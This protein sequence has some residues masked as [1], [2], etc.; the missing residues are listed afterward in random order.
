MPIEYPTT[1][2][3]SLWEDTLA[4]ACELTGRV[5]PPSTEEANS[6]KAHMM[7]ALRKIWD[8][9]PWPETIVYQ[10]EYFCQGLW[11]ETQS[12]VS[13]DFAYFA[14]TQKYYFCIADNSNAAPA[15]KAGAAQN[16]AYWIEAAIPQTAS[17][18]SWDPDLTYNQGDTVTWDYKGDN[19]LYIA[20]TSVPFGLTPGTFADYWKLV[21]VI[22]KSI[23]K[24]NYPTTGVRQDPAT[25]LSPSYIGEIIGMWNSDPRV[26][27]RARA[28][29]WSQ[30]GDTVY[31]ND[32]IGS[33]WVKVRYSPPDYFHGA[34]YTL[35]SVP[36]RFAAY[37][38]Y[39]AA[40]A[41]AFIDGKYDLGRGLSAE[42]EDI[43]S[44]ECD[45]ISGL[46]SQVYKISMT[47]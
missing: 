47:K 34:S 17:A 11:N 6:F 22:K 42:A 1:I 15:D 24:I 37:M 10:Q 2:R 5:Y 18:G 46:E 35:D 25:P 27:N 7:S 32:S 28:I 30:A 14:G 4:L 23:N 3:V 26:N 19:G 41:M 9:F 16:T 29:E 43:L 36:T 21:P 20:I 12:Y 40:A 38:S 8:A 39:R 31:V 33:V 44:Q 13:G 45:K